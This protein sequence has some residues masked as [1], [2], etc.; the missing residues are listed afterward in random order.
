MSTAI[1]TLS[2]QPEPQTENYDLMRAQ[3]A[4]AER[5]Q[6]ADEARRKISGIEGALA[7]MSPAVR[8]QE[9]LCAAGFGP[10]SARTSQQRGDLEEQLKSA[11][12]TLAAWL[13]QIDAIGKAALAQPPGPLDQIAAAVLNKPVAQLSLEERGVRLKLPQGSKPAELLLFSGRTLEF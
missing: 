5:R 11:K 2:I 13:G 9:I 12:E 3:N 1:E 7:D 4:I 6:H 8:R 10:P